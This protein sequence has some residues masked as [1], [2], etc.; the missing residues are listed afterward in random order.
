MTRVNQL[1]SKYGMTFNDIIE[2][3]DSIKVLS[4]ESFETL[5]L[6]VRSQEDSSDPNMHDIKKS[7]E[8]INLQISE[9]EY[10]VQGYVLKEKI[11]N[12]FESIGISNKSNS[13][14]DSVVFLEIIQEISKDHFKYENIISDI[15]TRNYIKNLMEVAR[16]TFLANRIESFFAL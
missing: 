6:L 15:S 3:N 16:E 9:N 7:L 14:K 13:D 1:L 5:Y 11:S 2:N 12:Y 10:N 8:G 4:R